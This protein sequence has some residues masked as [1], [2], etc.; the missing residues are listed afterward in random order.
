MDTTIQPTALVQLYINERARGRSWQQIAEKFDK[1]P[2]E[3]YADYMAH[4]EKS[5]QYTESEYRML[6]LTRLEK[7]I[8]ALWEL[9]IEGGSVEHIGKMLPIVQEISKLLALHKPKVEAEI[10]IVEEK[11]LHLI[12]DYIDAVTDTVRSRV[13]DTITA[14]RT[15]QLIDDNWEKW[16]AEASQQPLAQLE[17]ATIRPE[18]R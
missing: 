14:K 1:S 2:D 12:V 16:V 7:M 4:M 10:R 15:K 5:R 18:D 13:M 11:Q 3:V 9:G 6:Q 8:D 17:S